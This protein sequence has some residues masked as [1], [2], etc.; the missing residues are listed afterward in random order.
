MKLT[1]LPLG[2]AP[3]KAQIRQLYTTAFPKEEQMP[4]YVL[5]LLSLRRGRGVEGYYADGRFC[6]MTLTGW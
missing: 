1:R 5:R 4:W 3:S 2:K 6:G